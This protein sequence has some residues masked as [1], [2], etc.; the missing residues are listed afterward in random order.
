MGIVYEYN[1][2]GYRIRSGGASKVESSGYKLGRNHRC[3]WKSA[4]V[5]QPGHL[6][7]SK[8]KPKP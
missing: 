4:S 2:L 5:T 3:P 8:R 7:R 6:V 1:N